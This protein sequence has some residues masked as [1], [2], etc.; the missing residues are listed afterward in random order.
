MNIKL[1]TI[2]TYFCIL[3]LIH[4]ICSF[5]FNLISY[6]NR[7]YNYLIIQ[8]TVYFFQCATVPPSEQLSEV[9]DT[10]HGTDVPRATQLFC[11]PGG[12]TAYSCVLETHRHQ[13]TN[14]CLWP[15]HFYLIVD[16]FLIVF[17]LISV[18]FY[19]FQLF[20]SCWKWTDN[21]ERMKVNI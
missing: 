4:Y 9:S 5:I 1:L 6:D 14:L 7:F 2:E 16:K 17:R 12:C 10:P 19:M 20:L 21:N 15:L 8:L 3:K 13:V 18:Y 11:G